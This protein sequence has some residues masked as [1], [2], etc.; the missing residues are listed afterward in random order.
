MKRS[1]LKNYKVLLVTLISLLTITGIG[2]IDN[3]IWNI[4]LVCIGGLTYLIV[5]ILYSIGLITGK[6]EGGKVNLAVSIVLIIIGIIIYQGLRK[7]RQWLVSWP[8]AVK[9][10]VPIIILLLIAFVFVMMIVLNK[11]NNNNKL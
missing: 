8:P 7:F 1:A 4:I 2:F 3:A 11:K 6:K 10:I 9:T 5:E